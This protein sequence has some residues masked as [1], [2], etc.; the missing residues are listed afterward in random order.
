MKIYQEL[1]GEISSLVNSF[2]FDFYCIQSLFREKL[3]LKTKE[4]LKSCSV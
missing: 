4:A 1:A 2:L 3:Q